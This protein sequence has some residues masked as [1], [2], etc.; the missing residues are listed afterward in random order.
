MS[1]SA[2]ILV[3]KDETLSIN[4]IVNSG[5]EAGWKYYT[6]TDKAS[7]MLRGRLPEAYGLGTPA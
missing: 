1:R 2:A 4:E 5:I 6:L 3:I 7:E